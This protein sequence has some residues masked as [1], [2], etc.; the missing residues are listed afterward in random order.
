MYIRSS[1]DRR[2][3][4]FHLSSRFDLKII[5]T[6]CVKSLQLL[7]KIPILIKIFFPGGRFSY[8]DIVIVNEFKFSAYVRLFKAEFIPYM[9][10]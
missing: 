6:G 2:V 5:C 3:R 1:A 10:N 8:L 9:E 7:K 4:S